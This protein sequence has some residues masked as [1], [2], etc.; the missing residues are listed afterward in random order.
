MAVADTMSTQTAKTALVTGASR[1]IG[2][3][4]AR[5][6]AQ[7]GMRVLG[8]ATSADGVQAIKKSAAD[9]GANSNNGSDAVV[10]RAGDA[11]SLAQLLAACDAF[12]PD[13]V[14][15]VV[16]NAATNAD[17]LLIR[18]TAQQWDEVIATNLTAVFQLTQPLIRKMAK[19]RYGRV[20]LLSSVVAAIGN[21]GQANYCAAKAGL[22]GYC[23]AAARETAN[24]QVT[25]NAVAPGFI[26]TDMTN[27]LSD[28]VRQHFLANIPAGRAGTPEEVAEAVA[29][30]ASDAAAYITGQT[31]H[32]NGGMHCH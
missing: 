5:R 12:A 15:V 31:L 17:S 28:A 32:I 25:I 4:V 23:R 22:E 8:T 24:R 14:D 26:A 27:K 9:S 3:A 10:Y 1:G 7:A 18:M 19:K 30:L 6:L 16:A 11:E 13:G 29:F 20:V 2:A 21:P